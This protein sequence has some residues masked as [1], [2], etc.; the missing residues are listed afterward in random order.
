MTS[1]ENFIEK[2]FDRFFFKKLTKTSHESLCNL[3]NKLIPGYILLKNENGFYTHICYYTMKE[4]LRLLTLKKKDKITI[5][6]TGCSTNHGTKST[7]LWDQYVLYFDGKVLSVDLDKR[8]VDM[9]NYQTSN[10]TL[11]TCSDSLTYLPTITDTIDFLYLDS[12]DLDFNNPIPSAEHHLKE[13]NCVKHLLHKGSII[14]I[15][16]TPCSPEWLDHGKYNGNYQN[17][18][19]NFD[20]NMTGKGSLVNVELEKMGAKLVMH[21][22]QCLWIIP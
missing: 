3:N 17:F 11:I 19:N 10:K 14:L 6:E 22:Y 7:L 4:A 8:A 16:D 18:K 15:D 21:Q 13:F 12:Y 20:P 1:F 9:A 5:V 2:V